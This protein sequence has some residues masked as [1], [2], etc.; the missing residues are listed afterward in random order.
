VRNVLVNKE[1]LALFAAPFLRNACRMLATWAIAHLLVP[2]PRIV[3]ERRGP[4]H[5]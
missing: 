2:S 4:G 5:R 3:R 1:L